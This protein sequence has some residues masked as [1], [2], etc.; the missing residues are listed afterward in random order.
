MSIYFLLLFN[1]YL[2]KISN[3]LFFIYFLIFSTFAK[4]DYGEE[5]ELSL[6]NPDDQATNN[7][8]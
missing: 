2:N 6:E 5:P 7:G 4:A 8:I 1:F 3:H